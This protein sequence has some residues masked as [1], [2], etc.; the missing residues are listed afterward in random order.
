[1]KS[2]DYSIRVKLQ[3]L[4]S[5]L[6]ATCVTLTGTLRSAV[7]NGKSSVASLSTLTVLTN[8]STSPV[9]ISYSKHFKNQ[10]ASITVINL[11]SL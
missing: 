7:E 5:T 8:T 1:M 11:Q 9:G 6:E 2:S 4:K 10:V 3:L